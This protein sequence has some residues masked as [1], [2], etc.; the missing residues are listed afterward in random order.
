[1]F[2]IPS[3]D[4]IFYIIK[5]KVGFLMNWPNVIKRYSE[6]LIIKITK[7]RQSLE[8]KIKLLISTNTLYIINTKN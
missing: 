2:E 6:R 7:K 5:S 8:N 1:M 4:D 3:V